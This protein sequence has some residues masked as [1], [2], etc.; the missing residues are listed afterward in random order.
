MAEN[1]LLEPQNQK[2]EDPFLFEINLTKRYY[3][4]VVISK[5]N[6][7]NMSDIWNIVPYKLSKH[8]SHKVTKKLLGM[9]IQH[10]QIETN[11]PFVQRGEE[12][13]NQKPPYFTDIF[14]LQVDNYLILLYPFKIIARRCIEELLAKLNGLEFWKLNMNNFIQSNF[15]NTAK[16]I[17][18]DLG[19]SVL[20]INVAVKGVDNINS[21]SIEGEHPL[22]SNFYK[23]SLKTPIEAGTYTIDNILIKSSI[24]ITTNSY[25]KSRAKVHLDFFGNG[26]F[27]IHIGG[28]NLLSMA[29]LWKSLLESKCLYST[30]E[31]PIPRMKKD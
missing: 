23:D 10:R 1:L 9:E 26:K 27:F 22:D 14:I 12:N 16:Q 18:T 19:I 3:H 13:E 25:P 4:F 11:E 30:E 2:K 31:N 29:L 7:L 28:K 21:V 6:N 20:G 17:V 5:K 15:E 24:A 8:L